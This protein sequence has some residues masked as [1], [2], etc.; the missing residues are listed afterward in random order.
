MIQ[1]RRVS[2]GRQG[3]H[4][5]CGFGRIGLSF[6]EHRTGTDKHLGAGLSDLAD[7]VDDGS[8]TKGRLDHP[9]TVAGQR[10]GLQQRVQRV[11]KCDYR[12]RANGGDLVE[13]A[14][15]KLR[16]SCPLDWRMERLTAVRVSGGGAFRFSSQ[17]TT[18]RAA[19]TPIPAMSQ[20]TEVN[21]G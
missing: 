10:I 21:D 6:G 8:G 5:A 11:F 4:C 15:Y 12:H 13:N 20:R 14:F 7:G 16:E 2:S 1:N 17:S 18:V 3:E 19:C 9:Q